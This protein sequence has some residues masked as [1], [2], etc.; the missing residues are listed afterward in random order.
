VGDDIDSIRP[1]LRQHV[2]DMGIKPS[3]LP[4]EVLAAI[5]RLMERTDDEVFTVA[6]VFAE[7]SGVGTGYKESA[8][9]RTMQR[10]K[11]AGD[12]GCLERVG[13][14]GFRLCPAS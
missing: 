11:A 12:E 10:M 2:I 1:G 9:Y 8:V 7:M 14:Q 4:C 3:P 6:R 13:R 5:S